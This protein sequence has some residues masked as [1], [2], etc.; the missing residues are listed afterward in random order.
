MFFTFEFE[1]LQVRENS[2]AQMVWHCAFAHLRGNIAAQCND[3]GQK[4]NQWRVLFCFTCLVTLIAEYQAH[5]Q[6][7]FAL[8][9]LAAVRKQ[10]AWLVLRGQTMEWR[11]CRFATNACDLAFI[12]F[13]ACDRRDLHAK[14][15]WYAER[16]VS[17]SQRN[18]IYD[19]YASKQSNLHKTLGFTSTCTAC[20]MAQSRPNWRT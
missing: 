3:V 2:T 8:E 17:W 20:G 11:Q 9:S 7:F 13:L 14:D 5:W 1:M 19:V 18:V 10:A 6:A 16:R 15:A 12:F 4:S